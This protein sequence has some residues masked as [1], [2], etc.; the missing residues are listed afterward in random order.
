MDFAAIFRRERVPFVEV[1]PWRTHVRPG[2]FQPE[3][4]LVH[5]TGSTGYAGTLNVVRHGRGRFREHSLDARQAFER[6]L[7][8][9]RDFL[10]R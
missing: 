5:H 7:Y 2:T 6:R 3:G 8:R 10:C 9:T 4:V 1:G